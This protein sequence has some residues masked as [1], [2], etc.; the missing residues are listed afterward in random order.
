MTTLHHVRL[1][2]AREAGR[3]DGD[4]HTGYDL[5]VPLDGEGRLDATA[6]DVGSPEWRVRRFAKEDTLAI[7]RLRHGPGGR[8]LLDFESHPEE[9]AAGYRL[10]DERF[11][12]GEYVS[13]VPAKGPAHTY[14]VARVEALTELPAQV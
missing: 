9:Q 14:R 1:E 13:I 8:W 10:A 5:V 3:P 2:L 4:R 11:V 6:P 7:G 12:P